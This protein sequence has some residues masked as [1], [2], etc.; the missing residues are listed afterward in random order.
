MSDYRTIGPKEG[1]CNLCGSIGPLTEDHVPPKGCVAPRPAIIANILDRRNRR[2]RELPGI[3]AKH[4]VVFRTLC[5]KC[6]SERLGAEFDPELASMSN[7][8]VTL[9][10]IPL[11]IPSASV[12]RVR[13]QRVA[14]AVLGH[15][16]AVGLD[17][18]DG[19]EM[20]QGVREYIL[21][22]SAPNFR[23]E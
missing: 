23:R 22:T 5:S 14:R 12:I 16:M 10:D 4:G 19:G 1:R 9:I 17:R 13:P 6:N 2:D 11:Y 21:E 15:L 18:Y 20:T 7:Q 3:K 8:V